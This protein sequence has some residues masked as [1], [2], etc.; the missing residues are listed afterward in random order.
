MGNRVAAAA[1]VVAALFGGAGCA[2][3]GPSP[4]PTPTPT[5]ASR[6]VAA[7]SRCLADHSPWTVDLDTAHA[8][9]SRTADDPAH[10]VTGGEANGTATVAFTRGD[11]PR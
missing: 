7:A 9:W 8:E 2:A 4:S 3:A 10:P 1:V 5:P 11:D 6:D